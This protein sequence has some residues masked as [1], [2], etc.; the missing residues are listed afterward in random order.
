VQGARHFTGS[1]RYPELEKV[2]VSQPDRAVSPIV[3]GPELNEIWNQLDILLWAEFQKLSSSE[4]L[5]RHQG[6][7]PEDF[8]REPHRNRYAVLLNRTAHLAYHY[9]QAVLGKRS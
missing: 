6:I 8:L 7:S 2:F 3:S 5:R 4:W 9:G 1:R